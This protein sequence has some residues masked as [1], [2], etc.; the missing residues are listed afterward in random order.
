MLELSRGL[1]PAALTALVELERQS[2]AV[3][4]GRLKLE[5]GVLNARS[6]DLVED[7]LWWDGERLV[8]FLGLYAFWAPTVELVGMVHPAA[9]RRGIA[10][11]LL[12]AALPLCRTRD[13]DQVLLV[14]P[15]TSTAGRTLALRRGAQLEHSEHALVL[16][17]ATQEGTSDPLITVRR[18]TAADASAVSGLLTQAFGRP[19]DLTLERSTSDS[20][21]TLVIELC[22]EVVGTLR[23]SLDRDGAGVYGFAV[24]PAFQGR[25]VGRD[26]LRRV[27]SQLLSDGA[28]RVGLEVAVDN[29]RALRLYTSVGFTRVTTEDYYALPLAGR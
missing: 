21:R 23:V 24:D 26:V 10:T 8:G 7:L 16:A 11:A 27:C 9:R 1:S 15:R 4:G 25:G 2:I 19:H 14:V 6:G 29:D 12:D 20:E 18:A 22:G 28:Q 3:D 13:Y 17:G 5:W